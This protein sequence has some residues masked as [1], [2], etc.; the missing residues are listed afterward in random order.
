[1]IKAELARQIG[2]LVKG[3]T[4]VEIA[5]LLGI[6]QPK[7]SS[8]LRGKLKDFSTERLMSF[9]RA[10]G[11]DIEI[12]VRPRRVAEPLRLYANPARTFTSIAANPYAGGRLQYMNPDPQKF[13]TDRIPVN[14][15]TW[16]RLHVSGGT[17]GATGPLGEAIYLNE[18]A[19]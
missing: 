13:L 14:R 5:A 7:V 16:E 11:Q 12:R 15:P 4:Q 19:A 18:A 10:L 17:A 8:L 1:M 9:L 6:H 3:K 2:S